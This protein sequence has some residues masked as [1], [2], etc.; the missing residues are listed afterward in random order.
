MENP[1]NLDSEPGLFVYWSKHQFQLVMHW[2]TCMT[3]FTKL[4]KL[5]RCWVFSMMPLIFLTCL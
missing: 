3:F 2:I 5:A 4:L 1:L